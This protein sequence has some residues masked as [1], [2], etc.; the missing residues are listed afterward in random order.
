[1]VHAL[2]G[3]HQNVV[4]LLLERLEALRDPNCDLPRVIVLSGP[5]GSGKT[6][7]VQE[8]YARL[9]SLQKDTYWPAMGDVVR[10]RGGAGTDPM[11]GRKVVTPPIDGFVWPAGALPTFGWWGL[12][13]ERLSSG[14]SQDV[15]SAMRSQLE[16]HAL[17]LV[18]ARRQVEGLKDKTRRLAGEVVDE[19]R[20]AFVD[21]GLSAAF[22]ALKRSHISIP[23]G[24]TLVKWGIK[25]VDTSWRRMQELNRL[26]HDFLLGEQGR[27][28]Q[29]TAS[30]QLADMLIS[31]SYRDLPTVIAIE[32]MH[33]MGREMPAFLDAV[34]S[35]RSS[36][37]LVVGTVW[38]EGESNG[39]YRRWLSKAQSRGTVQ[40]L[41]SPIL[42][43]DGL[44]RMIQ[45]EAPRTS[46]ADLFQ[47]ADRLNN[48]YLIRLWLTERRTQE[49]IEGHDG[50][51]VLADENIRLP[52]DVM[53]VLKGRWDELDDAV[54][55]AV[56][57][58]AAISPDTDGSACRFVSE[59]VVGVV[60][61]REP[62][63]HYDARMGLRRAIEKLC[64]CRSEQ[65]VDLFVEPLLVEY[66][67]R[68]ADGYLGKEE[69]RQLRLLTQDALA[70]WICRRVD[71]VDLPPTEVSMFVCQWFLGVDGGDQTETLIMARAAAQWCLARNADSCDGVDDAVEHGKKALAALLA[72]NPL[73][74]KVVLDVRVAVAGYVLR[75][76]ESKDAMNRYDTLLP[77]FERVFGIHHPKTMMVRYGRACAMAGLGKLEECVAELSNLLE[78]QS[79]VLGGGHPDSWLTRVKLVEQLNLLGRAEELL[80]LCDDE[81]DVSESG[82]VAHDLFFG[83]LLKTAALVGDKRAGEAISVC[84]D[85]LRD[86]ERKLGL[87]HDSVLEAR[88]NLAAALRRDNRLGEA[89]TEYRLLVQG[90]ERVLGSDHP[91][92][93]VA[94]HN[95]ATVLR[96]VGRVEESVEAYREVLTDQLRVL[97]G[98]HLGTLTT[99]S[100]LAGVLWS[101]GRVEESVEAYRE[102]LT[103]QLRVLG[104]DH[105]LVLVTRHNL[106]TVLRDVGRVE[107]AIDAY[108]V[109]LTDQLRVRG[110]Y[111]P[112][113]L[114]TRSNLAGVL[115]S[116]G[117]VE[118]SVEAYREVLTDQ[119]RVLGSDHPDTLTTRS[120]IA[121]VLQ[122][123][124]RVEEAIDA[125]QVVLDDCLRVLGADHPDTLATRS[126]LAGALQAAGRVE[127]AVGVFQAVLTDRLRVLGSDHPDTLTTRSNIASVL[128]DVGRVEE[129]IDAY[130]VVLDDCLRVLGA[131]HPDTLATRSNLAGALQAAGRVEEAV[132]AY[133]AVLTDRLRVL[134]SDHPATLRARGN[135]AAALLEVGRAREAVGA[136][137]AVLA[138][139]VRVLGPDHPATLAVRHNLA[140]ALR[141]AGWEEEAVK[142]FQAVLPDLLRV[143]GPDHLSALLTRDNLVE[144]LSAAGRFD[145]TAS[146]YQSV[147]EARLSSS[148]PDDPDVL[149]A[150]DD[151]AWALGRAECFDEALA[152]YLKL[153]SDYE[154]VMGVDD[155]D[156]LTVRNNYICTL[157]NSGKIVEAVALYRELRSDVERALGADD[158]FAQEIAQRL[159]EWESQF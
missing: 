144:A 18:M 22:D 108:Q 149:D 125:Y 88:S 83:S 73:P 65:G 69:R 98:D 44:S 21:E 41:K 104:S 47:I 123:V 5:A 93:S 63:A 100:N 131:D 75:S 1:M 17:P 16:A 84:R 159:S 33:L 105:P 45:E 46:K 155:P 12:N 13:C 103:D 109:V 6:R 136:Y 7:I 29:R 14:N 158:E 53:A 117:R 2:L 107:E 156:T 85:L 110:S 67:R 9:R 96:D 127:E 54:R 31:L 51:V 130:Q 50:A 148:D 38:P 92:V 28:L 145:E 154:R 82:L 137:R 52:E 66:L 59:V 23:F 76:G 4:D 90:Y 78:D 150:R 61:R 101:V 55:N 26:K 64:W 30:Q 133:Q 114:A 11:A 32:D 126:N 24:A 91:M 122:D 153:I 36:P 86:M 8:L 87:D 95:L 134:G 49:H 58:A 152:D 141:V 142:S 139:Q 112:D 57:Y 20:G 115:W 106:A 118:E 143:L 10:T 15:V 157:R 60:N 146:V 68:K 99:R 77:A 35:R 132:G 19:V 138:D 43:V 119:L 56:F 40:H 70:E 42:E 102:V 121:S 25:G 135:L 89:V 34:S 62:D 79:A 151:L 94:R 48:P 124:G 111:H 113:T 120:N 39:V 80:A 140:V 27:S 129:A 72:E 3:E 116:V 81:V 37:V 97:G 147:V 74:E 128:Q 71:G